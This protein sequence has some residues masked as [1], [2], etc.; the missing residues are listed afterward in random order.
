LPPSNAGKKIT[1]PVEQVCL[2]TGK[3]LA[4]FSS[5]AEAAKSVDG[6]YREIGAVVFGWHG[7]KKYREFGWQRTNFQSKK[8]APKLATRNLKKP[9]KAQPALLQKAT[10]APVDNNNSAGME[11]ADDDMPQTPKMQLCRPSAY[12]KR[13]KTSKKRDAGELDPDGNPKPGKVQMRDEEEETDQEINSHLA[14][15][16]AMFTSVSLATASA[17]AAAAAI[18]AACI[19]LAANNRNVVCSD[20]LG[21]QISSFGFWH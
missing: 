15:P 9:P 5:M 14:S 18:C 12:C 1:V 13:Q 11:V 10:R 20:M 17:M 7:R 8:H 2:K 6:D 3:V 19:T 21:S 4:H 16:P